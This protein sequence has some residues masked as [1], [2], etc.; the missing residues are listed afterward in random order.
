M[1]PKPGSRR[2]QAAALS[3]RYQRDLWKYQEIK[4]I[5]YSGLTQSHASVPTTTTRVLIS[6]L[7]TR[8]LHCRIQRN[9][10]RSSIEQRLYRA[11]SRWA[12]TSKEEENIR[13]KEGGNKRW[14]RNQPK[15]VQSCQQSQGVEDASRQLCQAVT[16][17]T[18]ERKQQEMKSIKYSGLGQS[19][20]SLL[21]TTTTTTRA[22]VSTLRTR[23]L[24]C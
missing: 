5:K 18:S 14:L 10:P 12:K 11:T 19:Y 7:R 22:L 15:Y 20:A 6:T 9:W 24:H 1:S 4:S 13:L 16:I 2:C 17:E 23:K 3:G 21:T 8:K